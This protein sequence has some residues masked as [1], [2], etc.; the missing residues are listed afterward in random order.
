MVTEWIPD[1]SINPPNLVTDWTSEEQRRSD[2][3]L[4]NLDTRS[5]EIKWSRIGKRIKEVLIW[6]ML[7]LR[8]LGFI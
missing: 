5:N 8:R 1:I 3:E 7:S 4:F 2:S 6:D